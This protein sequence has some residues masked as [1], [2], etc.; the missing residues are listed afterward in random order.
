MSHVCKF[1]YIGVI[2]SMNLIR[3]QNKA[4]ILIC[5]FE[6]TITFFCQSLDEPELP[7]VLP[8]IYHKDFR[9]QSS[10]HSSYK[11]I[12]YLVHIVKSHFDEDEG[13]KESRETCVH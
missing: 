7:S 8:Q 12:V 2:S 1:C 13:S 6:L 10:K 9:P 4:H 11:D 5:T 3:N